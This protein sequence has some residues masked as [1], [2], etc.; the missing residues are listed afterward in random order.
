MKE[1]YWY[2]YGTQK[3]MQFWILLLTPDEYQFL[4]VPTMGQS[5]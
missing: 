1:G 2:D 5:D 4:N 3:Q